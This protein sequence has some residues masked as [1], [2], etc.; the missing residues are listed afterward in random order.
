[1]TL[2]HVVIAASGATLSEYVQERIW[3]RAGCEEDASWIVDSKGKEFGCIGLSA[4]LRDWARIGLLMANSGKV[5]DEQVLPR[6]W[7]F[8]ATTVAPG[9]V[10]LSPG[11]AVP[12]SRSGYGFLVWIDGYSRRRI[13]SMRGHQSQFVV[14]APDS[15]LVLA[16]TAVEFDDGDFNK[17]MYGIFTDL[18]SL[19][20]SGKL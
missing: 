5:R 2:A 8:R 7:V 16:Q 20:D 19:A 6:D 10:H 14:M 18:L 13:F 11:I 15:E 3:A 12:S 9:D 4:T 17:S 1:M